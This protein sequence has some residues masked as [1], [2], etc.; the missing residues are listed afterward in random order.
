MSV[1]REIYCARRVELNLFCNPYVGVDIDPPKK[2]SFRI[3]QERQRSREGARFGAL[4]P[5]D[6]GPR[7]SR[8]LTTSLKE[9]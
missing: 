7:T 8:S 3:I 2:V 6:C 5:S 1:G 4:W 9:L